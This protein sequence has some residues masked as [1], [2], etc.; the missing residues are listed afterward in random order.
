[1]IP[2]AADG[3]VRCSASFAKLA[4]LLPAMSAAGRPVH[5]LRVQRLVRLLP[6]C[7]E[8]R[9]LGCSVGV[10]IIPTPLAIASP[11]TP[12]PR[13]ASPNGRSSAT[14]PEARR[15]PATCWPASRAR[16]WIPARLREIAE[17]LHRAEL[18]A[19]ERAEHIAEWVRLTE[20]KQKGAETAG[21]GCAGSRKDGRRAGPQ[22]KP[23]GINAATRE[24]GIDRSEAQRAVKIAGIAEEA[25]RAATGWR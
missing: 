5:S 13:P 17:N 8:Q 11:P 23:S 7:R 19:L 20:Q 25:K 4:K 14:P 21:A 16:G 22:H 24:L 9:P 3:R 12:R 15:S 1:M 6:P 2:L 18:T 10:G